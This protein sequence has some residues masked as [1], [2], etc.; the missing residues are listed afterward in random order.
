[1]CGVIGVIS[2]KQRNSMG[3]LS[4]KLLRM[5]EYRGYDST[6]AI[7]QDEKGEIFFEKDVGSPTVVTNKYSIEKYSGKIFCGQ[8]RWA[9]F[10]VVD[11]S[12]AQPHL[13]RCKTYIYGAHNGNVTNCDQLKK[14]L[15]QEGHDVIGNNDGEM[16]VHCVEHF[17]ALELAKA[18][19]SSNDSNDSDD[20]KNKIHRQKAFKNAI[21]E[22]AKKLIGSYAAIIVD[23]I[24]E[25]M[26]AIKAGSSLY[27]GIGH[28]EDGEKYVLASSDLASVLSQTKILY[29]IMENEF[30]IFDDTANLNCYKLNNGERL[31]KSAK[32]SKLTIE[33]TE[34]KDQHKFFMQ[35]EIMSQADA[36]KKLISLFNGGSEL[37]K[38]LNTVTVTVNGAKEIFESIKN[39]IKYLSEIVEDKELLKLAKEFFVCSDF[40][41]LK[42]ITSKISINSINSLNFESSHASF[43]EELC[44]LSQ[45]NFKMKENDLRRG[46]RT[47][48]A[49]LMNDEAKD[50]QQKI[51]IF[52][53]IVGQ[54]HARGNTIYMLACGTSFH[55]AKSAAFFFDRVASVAIHPV[56]PGEFR[57][58]YENSIGENDV[59]IGISQSGE[60]KDLIDIFNLLKNKN[61]KINL[62]SIVNN[63]NSSLPQEKSDLYIPLCSG[64]EIAVP[65][66]KSFMNQLIVLYILALKIKQIKEQLKLQKTSS[67]AFTSTFTSAS[68]ST[69]FDI[70][71]HIPELIENTI[72]TTEKEIERVA[73]LIY[74]EPSI[75]ILGTGMYGIAREGALKIREVV[76]N[77]TEGFESSEFKHGPNTI[78]G[79]NTVFGFGSVTALLEKFCNVL[80][81]N[82]L[83]EMPGESIYKLFKQISDYAFKDVVPDLPNENEFTIFKKMF[84]Q[85]NFFDSLYS[86]YPLIFVTG[87]S[88]RET[89]LTISQINTHK[90]RGANI[91]IV[92]EENELLRDAIKVTDTSRFGS[93][94]KCGYIGLPKTGHEIHAFF[95]STVVL[96]LLA[97]K[98]SVK[99]MNLLDRLEIFDHGVHPDSPKNVSKSIT[100]D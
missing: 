58:Q 40:I 56:L 89:N 14:W 75:H 20:Q 9:T 90:I 98:M 5:L 11:K 63:T 3:A 36:A 48:D 30:A 34:L 79:V 27:I 28:N 65:A 39:K 68:A 45:K 94:Y 24:S 59:V 81:D 82:E 53:D 54:A 18:S 83:K 73:E 13:V 99:K 51:D 86:N 69:S 6:G 17:F 47:I 26:A 10:G 93:S 88:D 67:P 97:L 43:L 23:P 96:Q 57:G 85:H 52:V 62:I 77:H 80:A 8:V 61:F 44:R 41:K 74:N 55:A 7:I 32:R 4:K 46:L 16:V 38:N 19:A 70:L 92:A 71:N 76:L 100:V 64:P 15:E 95:S 22:A 29:P 72:K 2:Q 91:F 21:I 84:E 12:N 31:E 66:T 78:L 1:M 49:L 87:P 33:E 37:V 25:T 50:I 42:E 60:T 35:Q